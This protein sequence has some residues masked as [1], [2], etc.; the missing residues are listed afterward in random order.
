MSAGAAK[1]A[2]AGKRPR[3]ER[4]SLNPGDI[5]D[6]AFELAREIGIDNMSMLML[7]KHLNVSVTSIYWYFRKKDDLLDAMAERAL[8]EF[9]LTVP[10]IEVE[11]WRPSLAEHARAGRRDFLAH[12]ILVD[13]IL[14]RAVLSPRAEQLGATHADRVTDLLT[15]A[16]F[17]RLEA[18]T[19]YTAIQFHVR[20]AVVLQR[21]YDRNRESGTPGAYYD[22]LV[23]SPD[24][25][26]LLAR[27][28]ALGLHHGSPD[29]R[30]FEFGLQCLLDHAEIV[31][32]ASARQG[33]APEGR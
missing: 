6:G 26:P 10:L 15:E 23:A 2:S 4:G 18:E 32:A 30:N 25:T 20:A 27:A 16:G 33:T 5:L 21:L 12:P 29:D 13:L 14:V 7:G 19:L 17:P 9:R 24:T 31:L 8:H 11:R 28:H 22:T 3:R 1:R